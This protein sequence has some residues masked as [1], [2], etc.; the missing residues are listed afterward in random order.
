MQDLGEWWEKE[1]NLPIPLGCIAVRKDTTEDIK[2]LIEKS[3]Q[4][5]FLS[6]KN[7]PTLAWPFIKKHAQSL[8]NE[9]IQ[10]HIALY[11]NDFTREINEEGNKAIQELFQRIENSKI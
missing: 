9:A 1:T 7:N 10:A 5:S 4:V 2:T 3:I 8:S 6:T 11:V